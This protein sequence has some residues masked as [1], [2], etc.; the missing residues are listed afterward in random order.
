MMHHKNQLI[1]TITSSIYR[2]QTGNNGI[3]M[4]VGICVYGN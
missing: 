2:L 1:N 4:R 3:V